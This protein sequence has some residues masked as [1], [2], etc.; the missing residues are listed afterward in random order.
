MSFK[1]LHLSEKDFRATAEKIIKLAKPYQVSVLLSVGDSALT[2]YANNMIHQNV[3]S[4]TSFL[5]ITIMEEK[6]TV[7]EDIAGAITEDSIERAISH[8][9]A[10]IKHAIANEDTLP[11]IGEQKYRKVN[12]LCR[13][14]K[15]ISPD[16]RAKIVEEVARKSKLNRLSAG[17]IVSNGTTTFGI[18]NSEG[19]FA[20]H[21]STEFT[22][23]TTIQGDKTSGWA[24]GTGWSIDK[25]N[26]DT[27]IEDAIKYATVSKDLKELKPGKY[28]VVLTPDAVADLLL[29]SCIYGF[30]SRMHLEKQ[31]FLTGKVGKKVFSDLLTIDDDFTHPLVL[32][33]PFDY[34]GIPKKKV[35]LVEKGTLRGLVYDRLTAKK[36]KAEPT[37]HGLPQPNLWGAFPSCIVVHPGDASMEEM[38]CSVKD[39]LFVVH[40]HY[41]NVSEMTKLTI[42]GMT[43]DGIFAIK[44]GEIAYPMK[45]MRFTQSVLEAFQ[46]IAMIGKEQ[47]LVSTFF[48]G[49]FVTPGMVI[50]NFNFTSATEFAG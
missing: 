21:R 32:G 46:N 22:F 47:K 6:K 10:S 26:V 9:K 18:A 14:T 24:E 38:I 20:F 48:G 42:T 15:E 25:V 49:A 19:L 43:R 3:A 7:S 30:N 31:S 37:G 27:L 41:T 17:G 2:R 13:K 28:T 11:L 1:M 39:G 4:I 45:N 5:R 29:F 36:M 33:M 44:D 34:E 16:D 35:K 23:S 40:F 50:E 8:G 12:R